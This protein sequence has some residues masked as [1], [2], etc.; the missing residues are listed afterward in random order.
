MG[1]EGRGRANAIEEACQVVVDGLVTE[2]P[3]DPV[4]H[5]RLRVQVILDNLQASCCVL[6]FF[7]HHLQI[8]LFHVFSLMH[9]F[10]TD[11][12]EDEEGR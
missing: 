8:H 6:D 12:A 9:N 7:G 3:L 2:E 11:L 5:H 10:D 1:A 4:R